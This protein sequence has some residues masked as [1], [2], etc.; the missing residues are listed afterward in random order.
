VGHDLGRGK[1]DIG[2]V[3]GLLGALTATQAEHHP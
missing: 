3:V 1:F 2:K